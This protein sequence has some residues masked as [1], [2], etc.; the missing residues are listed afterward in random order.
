[1][2]T[3]ELVA[4]STFGFA[5]P[6]SNLNGAI[7]WG[8]ASSVRVSGATADLDAFTCSIAQASDFSISGLWNVSIAATA[9][10]TAQW[11]TAARLKSG[12][13]LFDLKFFNT[14]ASDPVLRTELILLKLTAPVTE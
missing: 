7:A 6:V 10:Q 8:L 3:I 1:M 11:W 2:Q 9:V 5:G 13:L 4:G 12:E 14:A